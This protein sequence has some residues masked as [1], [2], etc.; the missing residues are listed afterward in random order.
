MDKTKQGT[1]VIWQ[2]K[3]KFKKWL[4]D[5]DSDVV[6]KRQNIFFFGA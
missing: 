6:K 4:A 5:E 3:A 2:Y 1:S